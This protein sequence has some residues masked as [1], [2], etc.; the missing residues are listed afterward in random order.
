MKH[1]RLFY[2]SSYDRGL[3]ALLLIWPDILKNFPDAQLDICYGWDMFDIVAANNP[4]RQQWKNVVCGLMN[5]K[6]ITEHGRVGKEE[7]KRIR[8]SCGIWAYPSNFEEIH[9]ITALECQN[10][11]LVPVVMNLAALKETAKKG[12]LVE[13]NIKD[14]TVLVKYEEALLSLMSDKKRWKE[15]SRDCQKFARKFDWSTIA[16]A[17]VPVLESLPSYDEKITVFTP[18]VRE[19][20]WNLMAENLSHQT[21]KNFEWIIVDDH[22]DDRSALAQKYA[23]KYGLDIKYLRGKE[24]KK[25]TYSLVNANN[26]AIAAATGYLFVFLQDFI[27]LQPNALREVLRESLRHPGDFIAP[28]DVY[29]SPRITPDVKNAEDWFNGETDI[30]G[31][32]LR[33]NIRIQGE[34]LRRAKSITDFEQ[35]FG[36]VPTQTLRDLGGYYEFFDEALGFDDTEIIYRAQ[37]LGYSL[38]IDEWNIATC[39]DH[40]GTVGSVEG[41]VNRTRRL[42]DPRFSWMIKKIESGELPVRRTQEKD[43]A[44][45]LQYTIPDEISDEDCIDWMRKNIDTIVEGWV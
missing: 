1:H 43:D 7:L 14:P 26:T 36:A 15:L 3:D 16:D 42:N 27:L 38:W 33:K 20:W 34:G 10:D 9:C 8:S 6:G 31:E 39:I 37:K 25:R 4:E 19:G 24:H 44:I 13:G 23:E 21:H 32:I 2:G 18:T 35:N 12:I 41:G 5:Q 29:Y 28:V 22:K 40:W 17:W 11:G 45:D 30:A